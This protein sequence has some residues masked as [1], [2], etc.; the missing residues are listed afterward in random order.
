MVSDGSNT[1]IL[2]NLS[3]LS[4]EY[5]GDTL[6]NVNDEFK[7][8]FSTAVVSRVHTLFFQGFYETEDARTTQHP[9]ATSSTDGTASA[10]ER[11]PLADDPDRGDEDE[12]E[13]LIATDHEPGTLDSETPATQ[14]YRGAA[15]LDVSADGVQVSLTELTGA[16]GAGRRQV[17]TPK[18][19]IE[20]KI[21]ALWV[22]G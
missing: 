18:N 8:T 3:R 11:L 17:Y 10:D 21:T 19:P 16:G 13:A 7:A 22:R 20:K 14:D 6:E 2:M 15:N 5:F 1:S 12:V 4:E 9:G